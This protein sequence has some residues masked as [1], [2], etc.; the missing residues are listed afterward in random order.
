MIAASHD[1]GKLNQ[2]FYSRIQTI[3]GNEDTPL[4]KEIISSLNLADNKNLV[5]SLKFAEHAFNY[6]PGLSY[7]TVYSLTH[8][9]YLSSVVGRH[10]GFF[11]KDNS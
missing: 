4:C 3:I 5:K 9:H 2:Y 1:I 6:H 7:I 8:F 11:K 10:H